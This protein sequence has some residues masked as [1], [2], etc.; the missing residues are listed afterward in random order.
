MGTIIAFLLKIGFGGLVDKGIA[1][2]ETRARLANDRERLRAMTTVELAKAAVQETQVM[3]EFNTAKLAYWPF[4]LLVLLVAAPF[5]AWEW[6][7]VIDGMP[8]LREAFGDE[9]VANL[10]TPELRSA[11]ARMIEWTFYVGSGVGA[12]KVSG[13]MK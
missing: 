10:P 8:Y 3:A 11:F 13:I 12:L 6:A 9:Q 7:V 1:H 2:L 5:I 4:W